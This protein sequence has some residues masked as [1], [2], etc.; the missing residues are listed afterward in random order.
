MELV[1]TILESTGEHIGLAYGALAL[2]IAIA[3]PLAIM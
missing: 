3:V 1:K 2:S